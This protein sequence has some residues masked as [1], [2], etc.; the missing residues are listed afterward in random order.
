[1]IFFFKFFIYF[2][3]IILPPPRVTAFGAVLSFFID[4][5]IILFPENTLYLTLNFLNIHLKNT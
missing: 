1:M 2:L 3:F 5:I 4:F